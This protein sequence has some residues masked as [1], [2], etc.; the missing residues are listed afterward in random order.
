MNAHEAL[1][2]WTPAHRND[3]PTA[4]TVKVGPLMSDDMS[5]WTDSYAYTGGAAYQNRRDLR[6]D[7]SLKMLFVDFHTLVV[8]DGIEPQKAHEA[9]LIIDDYAKIFSSDINGAID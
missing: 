9:F 6:G 5:D 3:D 1:I 8:R 2:A 7:A 4:G